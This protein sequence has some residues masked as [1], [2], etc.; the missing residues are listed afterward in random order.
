[1]GGIRLVLIAAING[2]MEKCVKGHFAEGG[3]KKTLTELKNQL[4]SF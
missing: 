3:G 1:M 4:R 2:R